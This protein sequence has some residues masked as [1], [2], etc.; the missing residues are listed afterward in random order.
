M[1]EDITIQISNRLHDF[2][3]E[4]NII[5]QEMVDAEGVLKIMLIW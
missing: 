1:K 4:K 5:L 3:E 2:R